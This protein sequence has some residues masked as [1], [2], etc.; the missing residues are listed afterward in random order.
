MKKELYKTV[1]AVFILVAALVL[2]GCGL[3]GPTSTDVTIINE[4]TN[5]YKFWL[6][7]NLGDM[8]PVTEDAP[9]L[10]AGATGNFH[11]DG[12]LSALAAKDA[13]LSVTICETSNFAT[14]KAHNSSSSEYY[15]LTG[16]SLR[17]GVPYHKSSSGPSER[18]TVRIK[19]SD[20][21]VIE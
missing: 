13:V 5:S 9:V 20:S 14:L 2:S 11:I 8:Q 15:V 3:T 6:S 19:G 4:T 7:Y 16:C 18:Y 12:L 21:I 10:T 1:C 17:D